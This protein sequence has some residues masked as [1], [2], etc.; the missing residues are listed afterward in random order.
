MNKLQA[1]AVKKEGRA[2]HIHARGSFII[3]SAFEMMR[4]DRDVVADIAVHLH[5]RL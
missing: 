4:R 3:V 2:G 1:I 5:L